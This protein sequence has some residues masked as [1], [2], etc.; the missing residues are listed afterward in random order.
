[1]EIRITIPNYAKDGHT[2]ELE[3]STMSAYEFYNL[4]FNEPAYLIFN[5]RKREIE[6]SDYMYELIKENLYYL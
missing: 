3:L 2:H 6:I 5:G 4:D 1:M